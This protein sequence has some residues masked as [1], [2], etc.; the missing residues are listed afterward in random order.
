M[1]GDTSFEDVSLLLHMNGANGSTSFPDSS[2]Y[3]QTIT[4][5][6]NVAINT[7]Q[8]KFGGASAYFFPTSV[9]YLTTPLVLDYTQNLTIE[10]FC[11]TVSFQN[12]RTLVATRYQN[13]HGF[14]MRIQTNG[15]IRFWGYDGTGST[16]VDL[17]T[18]TAMTTGNWHH[19][20]VVK[21]GTA[22]GLYLNGVLEVTSNQT[23]NIVDYPG[24]KL[25]IGTYF[26]P[27]PTEIHYGYIDELRITKGVRYLG[28]F[29]PPTTEFL[30]YAGTVS[31]S[32]T[33]SLTASN[34]KTHAHKVSDGTYVGSTIASGTSYSLDTTTLE[35]VMVTMYPDFGA[36][37]AAT[38]FYP[39]NSRIYPTDNA[40]NPYYYICT[41][42][43]TSG[44]SEPAWP[45]VGT[46]SDGSVTWTY[47]ESMVQPIIHGPITPI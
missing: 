14:S 4:P 9:D 45:S 6:G 8:S 25:A 19:V 12:N 32:L 23:A 3:N 39:L 5:S 38:T 37:W 7:A 20:A 46:V 42:S 44:G 34:F 13:S 41:S 47:V 15:R 10:L 33:E 31:G 35:P 36:K 29:T 24:T 17:T 18:T 43:G 28:N 27:A 22:W 26:A 2:I 16:V 40:A 11:N 30:N 21:G 1:P